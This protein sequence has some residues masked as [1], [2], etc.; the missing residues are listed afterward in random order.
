MNEILLTSAE[1]ENNGWGTGDEKIDK[2]EG[3]HHFSTRR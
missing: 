2:I 3:V 1:R